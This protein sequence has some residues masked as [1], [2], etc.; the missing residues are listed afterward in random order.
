MASRPAGAPRPTS[1][2]SLFHQI[3]DKPDRATCNRRAA[4]VTGES[5]SI[6]HGRAGRRDGLPYSPP[7]RL[8][9]A[10]RAGDGLRRD[11]RD[12]RRSRET[13]RRARLRFEVLWRRPRRCRD[14][15]R[16][17]SAGGVGGRACRAWR[18][19]EW[20]PVLNY[21][22]GDAQ[23]TLALARTCQDRQDLTWRSQSGRLPIL[24]LPH[25]WLT[26]HQCIALPVAAEA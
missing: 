2:H 18:A 9:R 26:V 1:S 24:D 8:L 6:A 4:R 5:F 11:L 7:P 25:G 16:G 17:L 3:H 22:T 21:C 19:G 10:R 14:R 12:H 15:R 23:Q 20:G 13:R